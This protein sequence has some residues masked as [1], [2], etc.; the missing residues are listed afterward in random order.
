MRTGRS[1]AGGY[2]CAS[3]VR[4]PWEAV[5]RLAL[6]MV[7]LAGCGRLSFDEAR[8]DGPNGS[9]RP[10]RAFISKANQA[11]G[12]GGPAVADAVCAQEARDAGLTGTFVSFVASS[13]MPD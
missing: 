4:L 3:T 7:I 1:C 13:T 12:F 8:P 11:G 5:V 9:D 6:A 10:N 2:T